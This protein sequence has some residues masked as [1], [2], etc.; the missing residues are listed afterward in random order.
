MNIHYLVLQCSLNYAGTS[1]VTH[2]E[3]PC[4]T[5]TWSFHVENIEHKGLFS[6]I[7]HLNRY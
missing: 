3:K 2:V 7:R 1:V 6:I 4:G 5:T